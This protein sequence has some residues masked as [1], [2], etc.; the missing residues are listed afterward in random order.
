M[1]VNL[2]GEARE[3]ESPKTIEEIAES[4]SEGLKRAAVCGKVN[5]KLVDLAYSVN[6]D[7]DVQI[8]TFNDEEGKKVYNHTAA[9]ILAQA[10]KA[11]YPT[12]K[13]AIGPSIENGF[14]YDFDFKTPPTVDDLA[15]IEAE[16][17]RII[18]ANLPI[19]RQV[20]SRKKALEAMTKYDEIY[21]VELINDLPQDV[22]ISF[23]QQGD[24]VDLCAGPHLKSTRLI[25][26]FKLTSLAGA[27]W[28]GN[29][30]NKML[31]RIYGI[32][33]DSKT[34]LE[35]YLIALEEAKK[36]DHNKL[37]RELGIF[38][39]SD[40]IGQ[41]LPLLMPKGAKIIQI[42]QRFVEDE[43]ERR[44]FMLTKTPFMAKSDLYK[45][46]GHWNH[47]RDKM[48]VLGEEGKD[49]EVLALRP[50]TCP[51]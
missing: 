28:R 31:T 9:H 2:K 37:G 8:I 41:G 3:F 34:A 36:R 35:D 11:V 21:K 44:G 49:D 47:Y 38:M 45:I 43:E 30:N 12:A 20:I 17:K 32:A 42:L 26:A 19:E 4:I 16:M 22:E 24:F 23:Y 14:Y 51:F 50:M 7:S 48:F 25:K 29:V 33:F 1:I 13:L 40:V 6:E 15:R 27:Y 10:V 46:S 18:K 39:T 5:G